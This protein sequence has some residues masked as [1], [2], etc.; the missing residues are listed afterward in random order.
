VR[1]RVFIAIVLVVVV[2]AGAAA[3]GVAARDA[4]YHDE[5]LPGVGV[6]TIDLDRTLTVTVG[7]GH[8]RVHSDGAFE[9]DEPATEGAAWEAGRETFWSRVKQLALPSPPSVAVEPVLRPTARLDAL[10]DELEERA[11]LPAPRSARVALKGTE[12]VVV[13]SRPGRIVDRE[14]FA[15][16]LEAALRDG[17][18]A[19][20]APL[21]DDVPELD[22]AAAEEAAATVRRV[23][24]APVTLSFRGK[25]AG[26]LAPERL[27]RLVQVRPRRT[28][29]VV[30]FDRERVANAV[31][32]ALDPWRQRARN[33]RFVVA[34]GRVR[35]VPSRPGLDVNPKV[36]VESL[37]AAA[38]SDLRTAELALRETRADRTT[39]DAQ[40]LGIRERISTFT[41]EMGPSS[42]NRIHN[43]HLMAEFIDGTVIEPGELFSFNDSVGPRSSE[44]GFLEGQM[45]VGSLLLPAIGGGV[46]QTATTLF[47]NAW[48]LGLPIVSRYNHSFYIS[49]YPMGRDATVSWGGPDFVF[50]NDLKTGILIK[51]SYTNDT[52]TFSFYGTD[53]KRRVVTTTGPQVN[54]REP[55]TTYALDPYAP[56]GSMRVV[57]GSNQAG[58]DV[59]VSRKVYS[60]KKVLRSDSIT[61]NYIAVG[62]TAIYGPGRE[63]PGPYFVL[64]R[65]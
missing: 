21:V 4:M 64:P 1:W 8:L 24:R 43:V 3:A 9:I 38:Y 30:G 2:T 16:A 56:R 23:L 44:R 45:I 65:V 59:T 28:H 47:N 32:P 6:R 35:I 13:R 10:V 7:A 26:T 11:K 46:C 29:F 18:N 22:T 39:V 33:A 51:T 54:W 27:A 40:K 61:S 49:H 53:P 19:V 31:K 17:R 50:R 42:S 15:A 63:I 41:T 58:F 52:L 20:D 60:G 25:E 14:R 57:S 62:P 55:K 5:P 34:G 12:P 36:A 48:E 37:T